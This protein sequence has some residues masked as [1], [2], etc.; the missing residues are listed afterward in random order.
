MLQQ[1]TRAVQAGL[2]DT[3]YTP[4]PPLVGW[5]LAGSLAE[6]G[7]EIDSTRKWTPKHR[8]EHRLRYQISQDL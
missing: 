7:I 1:A 5:G 3:D 4:D 6:V 2:T 8:T